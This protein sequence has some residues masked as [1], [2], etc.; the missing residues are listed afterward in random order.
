MLLH[1]LIPST[2]EAKAGGFLWLLG[3]PDLRGE[4]Q[5]NQGYIERPCLKNK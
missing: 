4:F 2:S 1:I 5:E 3:Q